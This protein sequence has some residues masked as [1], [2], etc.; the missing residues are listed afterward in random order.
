M[1]R[2]GAD[3]EVSPWRAQGGPQS[4]FGVLDFESRPGEVGHHPADLGRFTLENGFVGR[5][6]NETPFD[7]HAT[8]ID[9]RHAHAV[10]KR[11]ARGQGD[12]QLRQLWLALQRV[13]ERLLAAC[14]ADVAVAEGGHAFYEGTYGR[15]RF[16]EFRVHRVSLQEPEAVINREVGEA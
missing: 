3:R 12:C 6:R 14:L 13:R 9:G 7:G 15:E 2:F 5:A 1:V 4:A 10:A 8:V 16:E 11:N